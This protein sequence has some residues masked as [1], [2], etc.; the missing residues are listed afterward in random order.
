[1]ERYGRTLQRHADRDEENLFTC[2]QTSFLGTARVR[3][4]L[5]TFPWHGPPN[6]AKLRA[7]RNVFRLRNVRRLDPD[8]HIPAVISKGRL[9]AA[10]R[11]SECNEGQLR[12][13]AGPL[14]PE[15]I[16]PLGFEL[17][18]LR[19]QHRVIAA[20]DLLSP[21]NRWW[22]VSLYDEETIDAGRRNTGEA[23]LVRA[24]LAGHFSNE[25]PPPDG[26]I[27]RRLQC[28]GSDDEQSRL[29]A[30]LTSGKQRYVKQ[31]QK[32][33]LLSQA[34]RELL[35]FVGLWD[36]FLPGV[37]HKV[38][39]LRCEEVGRQNLGLASFGSRTPRKSRAA[40]DI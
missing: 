14:P 10:L 5:L 3:L 2:L 40:G 20:E 15:L 7:L 28:G 16:F 25:R 21:T 34:A 31:F 12:D 19:G 13:L 24:E 36:D 39:S 17:Q 6:P 4:D 29:W 32:D 18:C 27:Y 8:N 1:M 23:S 11:A 33:P 26:E 9:Q 35:P 38:R 37:L 30:M 22:V